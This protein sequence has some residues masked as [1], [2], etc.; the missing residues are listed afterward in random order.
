[1]LD[2]NLMKQSVAYD[3]DLMENNF[4][5]L[6]IHDRYVHNEPPL[7]TNA[8]SYIVLLSVPSI[9]WL[10]KVI[11]NDQHKTTLLVMINT[12][13]LFVVGRPPSSESCIMYSLTACACYSS[14]GGPH[15]SGQIWP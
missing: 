3:V 14:S 11:V 13:L 5:C 9:L 4:F 1:M 12:K 2:M 7:F 15:A 6:L 8:V 10:F